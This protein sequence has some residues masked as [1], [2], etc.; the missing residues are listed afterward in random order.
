MANQDVKRPINNQ[1]IHESAE[2]R[3]AAMA[4]NV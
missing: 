1:D 2:A 4:D 3:K